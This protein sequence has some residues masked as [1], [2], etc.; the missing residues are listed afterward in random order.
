MLF[1]ENIRKELSDICLEEDYQKDIDS[2]IDSMLTADEPIPY[3]EFMKK[4]NLIMQRMEQWG[5]KQ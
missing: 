2:Y 4:S 3:D 5:K 1:N